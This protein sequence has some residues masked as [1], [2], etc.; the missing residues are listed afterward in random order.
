MLLKHLMELLNGCVDILTKLEDITSDLNYSDAQDVC[1]SLVCIFTSP[2][3]CPI[4][5]G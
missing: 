5:K 4:H 2:H 1:N 3:L